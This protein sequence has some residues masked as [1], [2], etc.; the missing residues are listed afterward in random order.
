MKS[1][2]NSTI[3]SA[4]PLEMGFRLGAKVRPAFLLRRY[5]AYNASARAWSEFEGE[6]FEKT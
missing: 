6:V 1:G 3:W 5:A 2:I 4:A